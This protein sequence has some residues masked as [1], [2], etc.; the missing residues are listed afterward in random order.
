[1]NLLVLIILVKTVVK[2]EAK[3]EVKGMGARC[4]DVG[5]VGDGGDKGVVDV[6][7]DIGVDDCCT[8]VCLFGF[9]SAKRQF[10]VFL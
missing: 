1:M 6:D 5:D 9:C 10:S 8:L 2:V 3:V 7:V 4:G